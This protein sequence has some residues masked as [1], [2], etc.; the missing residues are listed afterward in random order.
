MFLRAAF[1]PLPFYDVTF[2]FESAT[3]RRKTGTCGQDNV[4]VRLTIGEEIRETEF[5]KDSLDNPPVW[6]DTKYNYKIP[7]GINRG[8]LELIDDRNSIVGSTELNLQEILT[9]KE[10]DEVIQNESL[11]FK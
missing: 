8:F 5:Q 9:L 3:I 2:R 11:F 6:H 7:E 1:D 4:A 10:E